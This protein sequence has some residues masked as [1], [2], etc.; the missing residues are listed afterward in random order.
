MEKVKPALYLDKGVI[1]LFDL[2]KLSDNFQICFSEAT[3]F[4]LLNDK[5]DLREMELGLLNE[6]KA[7]YL[8]RDRDSDQ[9]VPIHTDAIELMKN[10]DPT[11]LELMVEPYR[12]MNGGGKSSMFDTLHHSLATF[13]NIDDDIRNFGPV[14]LELIESDKSLELSK[15][16]FP[17]MW[18]RELQSATKSWS[19]KQNMTLHSLFEQNPEL[20]LAL[21][22][23]FPRTTPTPTIVHLA[24]MLLG[25]LQMGSDRGIHS[26]DDLKSTKAARNGYVDCL[27]IMF[28][29]HCHVFF[30][31]DKATLRRFRLLNDFWGFKKSSALVSK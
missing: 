11:E 4:D 16:Q 14:F 24:A 28:G 8:Y 23:Y 9:V 31:T 10:V 1:G 7:L 19:Q 15:D 3:L 5:S 21:E 13:F 22:E 12:F 20:A 17:D 18:R 25:I 2:F 26:P 6:V 30:T 29:L 27:H